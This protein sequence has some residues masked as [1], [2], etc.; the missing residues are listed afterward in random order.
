MFHVFTS[1]LLEFSRDE[2][3][4]DRTIVR[5]FHV[6]N[7]ALLHVLQV[8]PQVEQV[9]RVFVG[10]LLDHVDHVLFGLV[11]HSLEMILL[12]TQLARI[13]SAGPMIV[14]DV[15]GVGHVAV[16][17]EL[18]KIRKEKRIFVR[19]LKITCSSQNRN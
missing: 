7:V 1:E 9:S 10:N 6:R 18:L 3:K 2:L 15:A 17:V 8:K 4:T 5:R 14:G 11:N 13:S 16:E 19:T 12:A